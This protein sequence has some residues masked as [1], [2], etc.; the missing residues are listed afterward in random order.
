MAL[1]LIPLSII[2]TTI[3]VFW[4]SSILYADTDPSVE[5][6]EPLPLEEAVAPTASPSPT[7]TDAPEKT[8][9]APGQ[10]SQKPAAIR[11]IELISEGHIRWTLTTQGAG[12]Q[13]AHLLPEQFERREEALDTD[14]IGIPEAKRAVGEMDLVTT[15]DKEYYPFTE[16]FQVMDWVDST[17]AR[18]PVIVGEES[19]AARSKVYHLLES[20][21][22]GATF[23]WPDPNAF[24][25]SEIYIEKRI[26][27][28]GNY[29]AT[30]SITLHNLGKKKLDYRMSQ[31]VFGWQSRAEGSML[32][33]RPNLTAA[34]CRVS[35]E[36][37]YE[38]FQELLDDNPTGLPISGTVSWVGIS[39]QYFL[40]ATLP[41]PASQAVCSMIAR[42]VGGNTDSSFG[43]VRSGWDQVQTVSLHGDEMP[44]CIPSWLPDTHPAAIANTPTCESLAK[45][46]PRETGETWQRAKKRALAL[47]QGDATRI[48]AI[49]AAYERLSRETLH[50]FDFHWYIGP[51]DLTELENMGKELYLSN[52][53]DFGILEFISR[54]MLALL[55]W[56]FEILSSWALAIVFLTI[57]VKLLLFPL[58]KKSL[59]QM[60]KMGELKPEMDK[61]KEKYEN[62]KQKLNQEMFALYKRHGVNPLGGCLPMFLQMPIYIAL[63]NTL[64]AS[65]NLYQQPL[66]GWV[67]D[68]TSPDPY[69]ILPVILGASMFLQQKL[70][71]TTMDNQQAQMMMYIMPVMFTGFMLFLP[72]GLVLYIFTN[73][74]LTLVQQFALNRNK[75]A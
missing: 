64:Y 5:Q 33:I 59:V 3:G 8:A 69:Y 37:Y 65:V 9:K 50:Q 36:P 2:A 57:V 44:S 13:S 29:T 18:T 17:G 19:G 27:L 6:P 61:V 52:T 62:D 41:K 43:L 35:D 21:A 40:L 51:K 10:S 45:V 54:P 75:A 70:S 60:K 38:E 42:P 11:T 71:P 24:P 28:D 14:G 12:V 67:T 26:E 53:L 73:T 56:F 68:L 16:S 25:E 46:L 72:S 4:L 23:I 31:D 7:P 30:A 55:N 66:F 49:S 39:D 47:A 20:S 63:Y 32:G 1:R 58:T 15:W 22:N 48:T 34:T 74:V